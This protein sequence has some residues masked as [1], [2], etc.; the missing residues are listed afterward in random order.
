MIGIRIVCTYEARKLAD[1]LVRLLCAEEHDTR[2]TFGRQSVG[3]I[4]AAQSSRD[5]VLIV[6]S[7]SALT[8]S[9]MHDWASAIDPSRLVEIAIAPGWPEMSRK[10]PVI[11]FSNWR[12]ERGGRA[13]NALNDRLRA[14]ARIVEPAKPPPKHAA[15]AMGMASVAAVGVAMGVRLNETPSHLPAQETQTAKVEE[16]PAIAMGGAVYSVEPAS[17]EDLLIPDI[18]PLRAR[19][20]SAAPQLDLEPVRLASLDEVREPT[21][22]DRLRELNP[23]RRNQ[24]EG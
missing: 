22:L 23:L 14:V 5:A 11:D 3:D 12:G 21:L 19:P 13:W 16:E 1:T 20:L 18:Q 17:I 8:Q 10:A 9:Y 7:P 24:D 4:E 6:W 15:L 2:L